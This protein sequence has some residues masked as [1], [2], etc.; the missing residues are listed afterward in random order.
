MD[1]MS[2]D[3]DFM[4][5]DNLENPMPR[6][7]GPH[8][9]HDLIKKENNQL[10]KL[11]VKF[12]IEDGIDRLLSYGKDISPE[13][14]K[15]TEQYV[16]HKEIPAH[17]HDGDFLTE[18]FKASSESVT[19]AA[20]NTYRKHIKANVLAP[21]YNPTAHEGS[22]VG[23]S[24][25]SLLDSEDIIRT[26]LSDK[27]SP[28]L[29]FET[30]LAYK[31][32]L[33]AILFCRLLGTITMPSDTSRAVRALNS[34][35]HALTQTSTVN[36]GEDDRRHEV[37]YSIRIC[38]KCLERIR[39]DADTWI[40][41]K[42]RSP[43][44]RLSSRP[45]SSKLDS[46]ASV[47]Q[48]VLLD[49]EKKK[50]KVGNIDG[51]DTYLTL[52]HF[53]F[54]VLYSPDDTKGCFLNK[55]QWFIYILV[56]KRSNMTEMQIMTV[57][58]VL[59]TL[60]ENA[61][62]DTAICQQLLKGDTDSQCLGY[63]EFWE[64]ALK[65][66][67]DKLKKTM[68]GSFKSMIYHYV[69]AVAEMAQRRTVLKKSTPW[70][71]AKMTDVSIEDLNNINK[72]F[73]TRSCEKIALCAKSPGVPVPKSR[74]DTHR[75]MWKGRFFGEIVNVLV[76]NYLKPSTK[77]S[78]I[79]GKVGQE[80]PLDQ[81]DRELNILKKLHQH[82]YIIDLLGFQ[83]NPSPVFM[84][85]ECHGENLVT[86]LTYRVKREQLMSLRDLLNTLCDPMINAV[87][88][89]NE[90]NI[91]LRDVVAKNFS[92]KANGYE[93]FTLKY[94]GFEL[95]RELKPDG[96]KYGRYK[97]YE[98]IG[99]DT[100]KEVDNNCYLGTKED[101][102]P[103]RWSAPESLLAPH[104]FSR[105]SDSWMLGCALYEVLTHG[106]QPYTELYGMTSDEVVQQVL[107]GV[108]IK[109]P[110]CIPDELHA[111]LLGS[112][113]LRP[114][115][116]K[117]VQ[118]LSEKMKLYRSQ[119]PKLGPMEISML[120]PP[121]ERDQQ[122]PTEP[123]RGIPGDLRDAF[124][125]PSAVRYTGSR[126]NILACHPDEI[127]ASD[128]QSSAHGTYQFGRKGDTFLE[129]KILPSLFPH[130]RT[131][132][133]IDC[134]THLS[135]PYVGRVLDFH[136]KED[137]LI[138]IS[139]YYDVKN[140]LLQTSLLRSNSVD[141]LLE[142]L[143]QV[144]SAMTYLHSEAIGLIHCDLRAS[145]IYVTQDDQIRIG[146]LGRA[147]LL[148]V[149]VY[150]SGLSDSVK[151]REMPKDQLRWAPLEVVRGGIYS[152]A[153]D[154]FMFG[155]LT[156]E[157]FNA[158]SADPDIV[159]SKMLVPY[160]HTP[161]NEIPKALGLRQHQLQPPEC[162]DWLYKL[163]N[164]CWL[165]ERSRRP[166]F[167]IIE[168]CLGERSLEPMQSCY[169]VADVSNKRMMMSAEVYR[170]LDEEDS[171]IYM[172]YKRGNIEQQEYLDHI[173]YTHNIGI[174]DF[175]YEPSEAT[176][177]HEHRGIDSKEEKT[178]LMKTFAKRI[179]KV[180]RRQ[181]MGSKS[182][183]SNVD[184]KGDEDGYENVVE[185]DPTYQGNESTVVKCDIPKPVNIGQRNRE[186]LPD[187]Q[188]GS[189]MG[190][191]EQDDGEEIYESYDDFGGGGGG[192]GGDDN[193]LQNQDPGYETV[194]IDTDD[195]VKEQPN[196]TQNMPVDDEIEKDED[197]YLLPNTNDSPYMLYVVNTEEVLE[198]KNVNAEE[199]VDMSDYNFYDSETALSVKEYEKAG[200]VCLRE[201]T[202][203]EKIAE[204]N[205]R[206]NFNVIDGEGEERPETRRSE[207]MTTSMQEQQEGER[208]KVIQGDGEDN[209]SRKTTDD[210]CDLESE[211][212]EASYDDAFSSRSECRT[213]N[214]T[215]Y[216]EKDNPSILRREDDLSQVTS[217]TTDC[218]GDMMKAGATNQ[219]RH[220]NK[221]SEEEEKM[222][223]DEL[224]VEE[225]EANIDEFSTNL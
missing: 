139:E 154:I 225:G 202:D 32:I 144:A 112:L 170:G 70:V 151:I 140:N 23:N 18:L 10:E 83:R 39:Q 82:K 212:E 130:G 137:K 168:A 159:T 100:S 178:G 157:V 108:R 53:E 215:E 175:P 42:V 61:D 95:A 102:I 85:T 43:V 101:Q 48:N 74:P 207:I 62:D 89:C 31:D 86:F 152:Q 38:L 206:S 127:T 173:Y 223:P 40:W 182:G 93:K 183:P 141:T 142:Q 21:L 198:D 6:H 41:K 49:N 19:I 161:A 216:V 148:E 54:A 136:S 185:G 104:H 68:R 123:D 134:L 116:R 153:S 126:T 184:G 87:E 213:D 4:S 149:G 73:I 77:R 25:K 210:S 160:P 203:M 120:H 125:Y 103:M 113:M 5:I 199:D 150:D 208:G 26:S 30:I 58:Y 191:Q 37:E 88:F 16:I 55:L 44:G 169:E 190:M 110:A 118:E 115:Q 9:R 222:V 135:H 27:T 34:Q 79:Y 36:T 186:A 181:K 94:S 12:K 174:Y 33:T 156:W 195:D 189:M 211:F 221:T 1:E 219:C 200:I 24:V 84:M 133:E 176:G 111:I 90:N 209:V 2:A 63:N 60:L 163:I 128:E 147:C 167:S 75:W 81:F 138:Q 96:G 162:P 67:S 165:D 69:P 197:G 17:Y 122:Q 129:E 179:T 45:S 3:Y 99:E 172:V 218:E 224:L 29:A 196:T 107:W 214:E 7:F 76:C 50:E 119:C 80:T 28:K 204:E 124:E 193:A 220:E 51:F 192:G 117:T 131:R 145:N 8:V 13:A 114:Q 98:T 65:R 143:R 155:Q 132:D 59:T 201:S 106:C 57:H 188:N 217:K 11:G 14:L 20:L 47:L 105:K 71:D 177:G 97:D 166:S 146:R 205:H 164:K 52:R 91:V 194:G 109:Q 64:E 15:R 56:K 22:N 72:D 121:P 187:S 78:A 66:S 171:D 46:L 35:L 158:H 92:I 180:F